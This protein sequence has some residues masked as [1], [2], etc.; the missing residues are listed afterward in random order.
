MFWGYFFACVAFFCFTMAIVT[1]IYFPQEEPK[2]K[3]KN[4][5]WWQDDPNRLV[6]CNGKYYH[7]K[8]TSYYPCGNI[9]N[10]GA[11]PVNIDENL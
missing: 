4:H 11:K 8:D 5:H 7:V 10:H 3:K 2:P 9:P 6:K 1:A